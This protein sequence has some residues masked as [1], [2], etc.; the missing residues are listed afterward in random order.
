METTIGVI[1]LGGMG[2]GIASRLLDQGFHIAVYNRTQSAADP[3]VARGARRAATP[4][5]AAAPGGIVITMVANDAALDSVATGAGGF[6]DRLGPQGVHVSM[7]TVSVGL[8]RALADRH[9]RHGSALV[10]APVFG[11]PDAAAG[12]KLTILQSG[13]AAAKARVKPVLE[14]ISQG[15]VDIGESVEAAPTGKIAGNF[16]I[17]SAMES[18]SEAFALLEKSGVDARIWH[19]LM[20]RTLF[21]GT[22]HTNY[23]RFILDRAFSPPGFRLALGA[24]D[25]GLALATGQEKQVPMPF[26]SV[27]RDRFLASMAQGRGEMDWT[28][29][30]L[31]VANDAGL[32][33]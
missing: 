30:A 14:A 22:I 27:L 9:A 15:I 4:A 6:L 10:A 12:G 11:R 17:A 21:A 20:T 18:M 8:V 25:V 28:A 19:D 29:I 33:R 7:S 3:L 32:K 23:G 26:A 31:D 5:E 1:G 13:P 2:G 24:K 16:L